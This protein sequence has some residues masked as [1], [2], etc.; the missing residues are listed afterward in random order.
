MNKRWFG[1]IYGSEKLIGNF[2]LAVMVHSWKQR[3]RE[4]KN[5]EID[6]LRSVEA[7][8]ARGIRDK[9]D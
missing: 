8:R 4:K 6:A 1:K 3:R 7:V 9:E 5:Y 2:L